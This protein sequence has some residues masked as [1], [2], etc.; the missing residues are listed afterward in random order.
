MVELLSK[1]Q[2]AE[3]NE[4]FGLYDTDRD[5]R[6]TMAELITVMRA[7]GQNPTEEEIADGNTNKTVDFAEFLTLM[8]KKSKNIDSEED[9]KAAFRVFDKDHNGFISAAELRHVL[10]NLGEKLTDEEADEM[11]RSAESDTDG[12][13][14]IVYEKFVKTMIA[15]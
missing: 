15:K 12:D 5:G 3:Y 10:T 8:S 11:L 7:L 13:G 1:D 6:I 9:L 14:Q 2:I 4:A